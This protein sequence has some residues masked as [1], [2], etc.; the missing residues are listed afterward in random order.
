MA[1]QLR[2]LIVEDSEDDAALLLRELRRGGHDPIYQRVD[3]PAAMRAALE[4]QAWDIVLSDH[5]MP[6]FSAPAALALLKNSG[7]DLPFIIVSG[8][9]GEEAAVTAMKA[10]AQDYIMKGS[11]A[12]LNPAVE[13]ELQGA[14]G[15]RARRLAED[16]EQ[17]L[18]NRL[19]EEHRQL[20]QRVR[21]LTALNRLFQEHLNQRIAMVEGYREILEGLEGLARQAT[22]L[23]ELARSQTFPDPGDLLGLDADGAI[24]SAER[25]ASTEA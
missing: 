5:N 15:H 10:G 19:E 23:A 12:R 16:E 17:R 14:E 25:K 13:R 21:E 20:E 7:L 24:D 2:V 9:L 3:S 1:D 22:E 11:L 6:R 4:E 8:V 18:H